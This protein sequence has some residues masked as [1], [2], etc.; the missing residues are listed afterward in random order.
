MTLAAPD[1]RLEP[2]ILSVVG[3]DDVLSTT[4]AAALAD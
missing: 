1:P 3:V 2:S 4:G